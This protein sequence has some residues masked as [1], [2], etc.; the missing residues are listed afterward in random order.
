MR[1]IKKVK[2]R[3]VPMLN[4]AVLLLYAVFST[5]LII[6]NMAKVFGVDMSE[7]SVVQNLN[8][9]RITNIVMAFAIAFMIY[10]FESNVVG[11][12]NS[13][14]LEMKKRIDGTNITHALNAI[15][16][17]NLL[18]TVR[19]LIDVFNT[20]YMYNKIWFICM[21][22]VN[23]WWFERIYGKFRGLSVT[24]DDIDG[25]TDIGKSNA[26]LSKSL[27]SSL[28]AKRL[29]A[30]EEGIKLDKSLLTKE[31]RR[32]LREGRSEAVTNLVSD[33][34]GAKKVVSSVGSAVAGTDTEGIK[35]KASRIRV[36]SEA[37][38]AIGDAK[39]E[40]NTARVESVTSKVGNIVDTVDAVK[41]AGG[42][43]NSSTGIT[44]GKIAGTVQLVND[45]RVAVDKK[46]FING[47]CNSLKINKEVTSR[48]SFETIN[49]IAK[50]NSDF[51]RVVYLAEEDIKNGEVNE[52]Y[53]NIIEA[54]A[55]VD[56]LDSEEVATLLLV[57]TKLRGLEVAY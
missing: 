11:L 55:N 57:A 46:E 49:K 53:A 51:A 18:L 10:M 6:P 19:L 7:G 27:G 54:A 4:V 15:V 37:V 32:E 28:E 47:V 24:Q 48:P 22:V 34:H 2:M 12:Y 56:Y 43:L 25:V 39:V 31:E 5:L 52:E 14:T 40:L 42:R 17:V 44:V 35:E 13:V 3:A 50:N 33:I 38:K 41:D 9:M 26:G 23:Y 30:A 36:K 8:A 45:Y 29:R 21:A 1:K 16:V 20:G